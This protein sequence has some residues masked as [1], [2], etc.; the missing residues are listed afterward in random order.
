MLALGGVA[1]EIIRNS[2]DFHRRQIRF[3]FA[4]L[5]AG[6]EIEACTK[7]AERGLFCS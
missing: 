2:W 3:H 1:T 6:R 5:T 7:T 4:V